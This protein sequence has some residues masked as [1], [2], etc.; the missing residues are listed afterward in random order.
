MKHI[1]HYILLVFVFF[2]FQNVFS[3]SI[4][5]ENKN[6]KISGT[7]VIGATSIGGE[8]YQ[9][10]GIRGDFPL[11]KF[12]FGLDIQL[13]LDANGNI[14]K[15]DWD[16]WTDYLDKIYYLRYGQK[17]DAFYIKL[18]GLDYTYLGYA[19]IVN[20][21]SNMI[22]YPTIKRLGM[23][24][25]IEINDV[26]AEVFA[27]NFKEL[28]RDNSSILFGTRLSYKVLGDLEIGATIVTDLN[29][30]NGLED[31]DEDGIPDDIDEFPN[32]KDLATEIEL[33]RSKGI[34]EPA[35]FELTEAG[36][37]SPTEKEDLFNLKKETSQSMVLGLD[38]GYPVFEGDKIKIDVY[39]QF[40]HIIEYGWG[41]TFP[42]VRVGI[43]DFLTLKAEY[44]KQSKEFLYGYYDYTYELERAFFQR[45]PIDSTLNVKTKKESLKNIEESLQGYFAGLSLNLSNWIILD[46]AYQDLR[47]NGRDVKSIR[48]ELALGKTLIPKITTAKA[49]Y[50]QNNVENF[51]VWK[52]PSTILGY[53]VAYRLGNIDLGFDYRYTFQDKNGDGKIKGDNEVL[54]TVGLR[55]GMKF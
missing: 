9:Q 18:G 22:E 37:L 14:R 27:N 2:Y 32:N 28:F 3:Q 44:R 21:Y 4:Q 33:Y 41:L 10:I 39:S 30:Y 11:G 13:Y 45:N 26:K 5:T 24:M 35:I 17:N 20:G 1:Y 50:Y 38:I 16:E 12:G 43:G 54:K 40:S 46:I 29:E 55:A 23:E 48:G 7:A 19:N 47:G 25:A 36:L 8:N 53:V 51:Q 15:D 31:K 42:G 34:T 6:D 49:Y 52:T